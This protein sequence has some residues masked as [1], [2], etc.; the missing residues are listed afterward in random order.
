MISLLS[1]VRYFNSAFTFG[2]GGGI[3]EAALIGAAFGGAKSLATGEDPLEGALLGGLTSG[4]MNGVMGA[5]GSAAT[6]GVSAGAEA[7]DQ[8]TKEAL[9]QGTIQ[10]GVIQGANTGL[11][12]AGAGGMGTEGIAAYNGAVAPNFASVPTTASIN[13]GIAGIP[14]QMGG[15]GAGSTVPVGT[16]ITQGAVNAGRAAEQTAASNINGTIAPQEVTGDSSF[17]NKPGFDARKYFDPNSTVGKGLEWA[18]QNEPLAAGIAGAG[19]GAL[20]YKPNIPVIPKEKSKLAG[21]DR[22]EFDPYIASSDVYHPTYGAQGGVMQSYADGGIAALANGPQGMG[23]NQGYPG[24]RLDSTQYATPSQMPTSSAVVGAD[25]EQ[26]TNPYTGEPSPGMAQGGIAGYAM[27]GMPSYGSNGLFNNADPNQV[28]YDSTTGQY[29]TQNTPQQ[30]LK[31]ILSGSPIAANDFTNMWSGKPAG[32]NYL[33]NPFGSSNNSGPAPAA[34]IYHPTYDGTQAAQAAQAPAQVASAPA[35]N[36][37]LADSMSLLQ[38]TNPG[39][40]AAIPQGST[41]APADKKAAGGIAGFNLGGY[42]DGGNPRLLKGPGDGM[43]DN[44]PATI[45]G[46]QPARLADGEFVVPADVVSHLGNG[47]TDAGAKHLYNM[48]DKIRQARTGKKSQGKQ[49]NPA[50]YLPA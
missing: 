5:F 43:S 13:S 9:T 31:N 36:Y 44:I 45:G 46:K 29:Y 50:K 41:P 11:N 49:I 22:S 24:G 30:S 48:M 3:G 2:L 6:P 1:L 38:A 39:I 14:G 40:A 35:S 47:S 32:R 19:Y 27:G 28:Y 33:G 37:S 42:A 4:A 10:N 8:A 7:V 16:D 12:V 34:Q 17:W 23:N 21:Y 20:T 25:Y 18:K 26:A 15:F